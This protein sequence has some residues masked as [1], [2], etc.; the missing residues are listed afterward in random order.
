MAFPT[1]IFALELGDTPWQVL[2]RLALFG[3]SYGPIPQHI[4]FILDGNRRY[5]KQLS[6]PIATGHAAGADK[7][8]DACFQIH[9]P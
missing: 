5:A 2:K 3:I 1:N 7:L 6:L 4:A 8:F 9:I